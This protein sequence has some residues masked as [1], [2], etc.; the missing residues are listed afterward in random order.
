M[1]LGPGGTFYVA[2]AEADEILEGQLYRGSPDIVASPELV[3]QTI[4]TNGTVVL[5]AAVAGTNLAYQWSFNGSPIAGAT[6]SLYM[7]SPAGSSAAGAYSVAMSNSYYN[8]TTPPAQLSVTN[9]SN[10]GRLVNL[11][12]NAVAG[13][14][15]QLLTVGF[16]TG[17]AGTSGSETMLVQALGPKLTSL[18]VAGVMPDPQLTVFNAAQ[19]QIGF[20]AGWGSP[21]SNQAAVIA[22]DTA[23]YATALT[24]P[25]SKDSATVIPLA[26]GGYT[27]QVGS[28]SGVT[29]RTLAAFYDDTPAG[30]YTVT[31]PRLINLSCRLQV[32]ANSSLTAGFYVEGATSKTVLI[33]ANGPALLAQGVT[34][35]M[36]D[37]KLTV[38]DASQN[39]IDFN[40]GWGGSPTLAS[41]AAA[42]YAQPFTNPAS[43]DSEVVLTLPPGGY[44][45]QV[46]S[47]SNTPGDVMIEVY[48]VP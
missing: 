33:R 28:A 8:L 13:S 46:A 1:A 36:P 44:T 2:D 22:A 29:G 43:K 25:T 10:P 20:N 30:A 15:S 18:G 31:T 4:A 35:V 11:S 40:A 14:G 39:V 47:V 17:G 7:I 9:T 23:T 19:S 32:A 24:D 12:V 16:Y 34:G 6:N 42:V 21:A 48:E 27:I 45:A 26:P 38:Y 5:Q 41:I 3:A 37:P